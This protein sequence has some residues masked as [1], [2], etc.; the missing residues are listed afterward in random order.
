MTVQTFLRR[1]AAGGALMLLAAIAIVH[2]GTT[3]EGRT[4]NAALLDQYFAA[5]NDHNVAALDDVTGENYV[6]HDAQPQ[7]LAA[8]LRSR[9][10]PLRCPLFCYFSDT[11]NTVRL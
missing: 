5:V 7:P 9:C 1:F 8:P 2:R 3:A 4:S 11:G 6:Q 10:R